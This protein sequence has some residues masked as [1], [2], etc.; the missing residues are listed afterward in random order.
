MKKKTLYLVDVSAM[1][2]RAFYAI[3]PLTNKKGFQTNAIYGFLTM[4]IKLLN[5]KKPDY[6]V[7]CCDQKEPSFRK[8][9]D[10]NY[11]A[12]RSEMPEE[13]GSQLPFIFNFIDALGIPSF[14]KKG[15]EADDI[16]GTLAK[17]GDEAGYEVYI[18][19]SD[20]DFGQCITQNVTLYDS[21]KEKL[22]DPEGVEKKWGV[23]PDQFIDY[24]SLIGDSSD[25]VPGVKGIGPKGA[26]KLL[27]EFG[28]LD[29]IY[30]NIDKISGAN[31]KKLIEG[32]D[33]A[34]CSKKLVTIVT[35]VKIE[36]SEE[37][38]S[39]KPKNN[40]QILEYL[41]ELE[42]QSF[43][44]SLLDEE[45]I[46]QSTGDSAKTGAKLTSEDHYEIQIITDLDSF[47]DQDFEQFYCFS[48]EDGFVLADFKKKTAFFVMA[49]LSE[50]FFKFV[51]DKDV[52]WSGF[53]LKNL[54]KKSGIENIKVS[55]DSEVAAYTLYAGFKNFETLYKRLFNKELLK[56]DQF[57]T[58]TQFMNFFISSQK[59]V[60]KQ[61]KKDLDENPWASKIYEEIEKPITPI[62]R[63]MENKGILL[64]TAELLKQRKDLEDQCQKMESEIY[65]LA[66]E[67]FNILS[68]KQLGVVLF[69]NLNIPS[70]KKTKTGRST[71]VEVLEKLSKDHPICAFVLKYREFKKLLSTYVESLPKMIRPETKRIHTT[72]NQTLTTT[73][74]LSSENPNLQNIP[75]RT[76]RGELVRKAFVSLPGYKLLSVDYSQIE[77]RILAHVSKDKR[78][79]EA[80]QNDED[81]HAATASEIFQINLNDITSDKR[82]VAK[83]VNFG[84]AYGQ[85][86]FGL[87]ETLGI[88]RSES[89]EIIETYFKKFPGIKEYRDSTID[90]AKQ[91]GFVEFLTGRRRYLP[92]LQSK[93]KMLAKFG[94][95]AAINAPIQGL[96]SDIVKIAMIKVDKEIH[97]PLLLQVH[98][99]LIFEVKDENLETVK[100]QVKGIMESAYSLSVPLKANA[101]SGLSWWEAH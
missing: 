79:I 93:N 14:G 58:Q 29:K 22:Y 46:P 45:H 1:F 43:E 51:A 32:Q 60:F 72:F 56:E 53:Q 36:M 66:G 73:G 78:L 34:K 87:A 9:L 96:A 82:R 98:D 17:W 64:D 71:G 65:K 94:E 61:I 28:S 88:S 62:L 2:F 92:E 91:N 101:N 80:F 75:I 49:H 24:L 85:G 6:I 41:N 31:Q 27:S 86:A 68:P 38:I 39:K 52:S 5:T 4:T 74:R 50:S 89:K 99:E 37:T 30:E 7:Y 100:D 97:S 25:N 95:R 13:L 21:V 90:F 10:Q 11:K 15:F 70:L 67:E 77:L 23:S 19:S 59:E 63:K 3:P 55:F 44:R 42:F 54:F 76:E 83:A 35:D 18:V 40:K 47:T 16:I 20:K 81:I 57:E 12:N 48:F 26:V 84:I 69:D 8:E 33:S